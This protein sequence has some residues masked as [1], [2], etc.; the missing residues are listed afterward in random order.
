[1]A[2]TSMQAVVALLTIMQQMVGQGSIPVVVATIHPMVI[3]VVVVKIL[4]V[5]RDSVVMQVVIV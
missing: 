2:P 1:M 3:L 4:I 5:V